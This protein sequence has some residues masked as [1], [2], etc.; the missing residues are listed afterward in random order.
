MMNRKFTDLLV[1]T[2]CLSAVAAFHNF[3]IAD[4]QTTQPAVQPSRPRQTPTPTVTPTP[5]PKPAPTASPVI[6]DDG[7][8]INIKTELVN[9]SVRVVDR[10]NRSIGTLKQED[11]KIYEDNAVQPIEFFTKAEVPTNYSLVVDNSGSLRFQLDKIIEAS[12][13]IVATNR[14]D[15]ETSVIRFISSEKIEILQD[16]TPDKNL[17]NDALEDFHVDGG[18]TA[19]IDA[20]YLAAERVTEYEKTRQD[21][22]KR[23]ALILISD[24]E[25]RDSFYNEKQLFDS[26]KETDVQIFVIGFVNDLDKEGGLISKSPQS[27]A[28][29]FLERLATETGGK[30][31][32]P[33]DISELNGIA[34]NIASELRTQYLISYEPTNDKQDGSVR[35]NKVAVADGPNKQKR[36]AVTR[37]S[38]KALGANSA[39]VL[40]GQKPKT[41]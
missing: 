32:F 17:L 9:L 16:F 39:P 6:E 14:P 27:K 30:S 13:I 18:K 7:G 11:F 12:K 4:A 35:N 24:G 10:N 38:R 28:K 5:T 21:D 15:D 26:L 36:I 37:S 40:Q 8:E 34:A 29:S 33:N 1:L 41:K 31:Y 2:L 20:V 23:R 25:D 22:R 3:S 19:I